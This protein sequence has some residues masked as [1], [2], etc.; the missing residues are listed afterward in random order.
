MTTSTICSGPVLSFDDA[1]CLRV[2][3]TCAYKDKQVQVRPRF[4]PT[5]VSF[6]CAVAANGIEEN[7]C[8][9]SSTA[10]SSLLQVLPFTTVSNLLRRS[11][12]VFRVRV[13]VDS[14]TYTQKTQ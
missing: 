10:S 4:D 9:S 6:P 12:S 3:C 14:I 2:I 7:K 8:L 11:R 13:H 5:T 1:F